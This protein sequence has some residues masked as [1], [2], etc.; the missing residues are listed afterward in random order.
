MTDRSTPALQL[1]E[2]QPELAPGRLTPAERRWEVPP[3]PPSTPDSCAVS[4]R[5]ILWN[6]TH[7]TAPMA[8]ADTPVTPAS[9]IPSTS[10]SAAMMIK[11]VT[12]G[13]TRRT[14]ATTDQA[15]QVR[16]LCIVLSGG[17][18]IR[19]YCGRSVKELL[20]EAGRPRDKGR[21][22]AR[23]RS[24]CTPGQISVSQ[25]RIGGDWRGRAW[26]LGSPGCRGG[27]RA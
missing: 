11:N 17:S 24:A 18:L 3:T 7:P 26:P 21:E 8:M 16:R 19:L 6:C 15:T 9:T 5:H 20:T 1:G 13:L 12:T 14:P 10:T 23:N 22:L 27:R 2:A 4:E 25:R